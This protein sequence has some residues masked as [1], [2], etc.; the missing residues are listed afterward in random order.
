MSFSL[1][2]DF[3]AKTQHPGDE[4]LDEFSFPALTEFVGDQEEDGP[5]CP[6]RAV[7]EYLRRTK[8]CRPSCSRLFVTVSEPRRLFIHI[9]SLCRF[10]K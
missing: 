4:S 2:R 6:V 7:R 1:A 10:T 5:L 8:D 3:L 9:L